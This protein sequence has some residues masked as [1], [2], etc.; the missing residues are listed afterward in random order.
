M[1]AKEGIE[2]GLKCVVRV[3]DAW[4]IVFP[5]DSRV[6]NAVE[7]VRNWCSGSGDFATLKAV[8][9][10]ASDAAVEADDPMNV[11]SDV[12]L[13]R[14]IHAANAASSIADAA[15]SACEVRSERQLGPDSV[16][17]AIG[18][19]AKFSLNASKN[20]TEEEAWQRAALAD[21]LRGTLE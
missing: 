3:V 14:A 12:A 13:T 9:L 17:L 4:T 11:P 19:A 6:A 2:F 10:A 5:Q 18:Y 15:R 21:V 1:S 16:S 8:S 7:A 20:E